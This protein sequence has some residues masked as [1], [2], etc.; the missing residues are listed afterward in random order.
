MPPP[1][2]V[3][4]RAVLTMTV[5][6]ENADNFEREWTR[7]AHWIAHQ[8]GCLRQTLS[9]S[10]EPEAMY[11]ITSDWT[12][13]P[14]YQRF[15]RSAGQDNMTAALRAL[16][17]TARMEILTVVAHREAADRAGHGARGGE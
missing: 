10:A 14:T 4:V 15:E 13:L 2:G 17:S 3:G 6:A 8:D 11:I 1:A 9:R 12:D 7:V 16:R 5:P